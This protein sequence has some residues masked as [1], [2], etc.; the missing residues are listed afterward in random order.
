MINNNK[1]FED[2]SE[3]Y[4]NNLYNIFSYESI[5]KIIPLM[6]MFIFI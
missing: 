4:K 3:D 5:K 1:N 2:N 6:A